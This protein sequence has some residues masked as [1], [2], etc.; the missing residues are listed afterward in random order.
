MARSGKHAPD[1]TLIR[2]V[3]NAIDRAQ[4]DALWLVV[5]IYALNAGVR[6]NLVGVLTDAHGFGGAFGA[7]GIT[8]YAVFS[9]CISH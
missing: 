7:A 8:V 1:A 5:K 4:L 6:V 3:D 9:N 2:H